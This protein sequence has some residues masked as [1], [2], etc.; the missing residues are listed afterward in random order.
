MPVNPLAKQKKKY[1]F[2]IYTIKAQSNYNTK[3][4]VNKII[5]YYT[6]YK[7]FKKNYKS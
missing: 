1:K 7:T 2:A 6:T 5:N 4:M 3:Q